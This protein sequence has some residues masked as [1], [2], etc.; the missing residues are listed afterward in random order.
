MMLYTLARRAEQRHLLAE[1][2]LTKRMQPSVEVWLVL[3]HARAFGA[4][5]VGGSATAIGVRVGVRVDGV[6][7]RGR[8]GVDGAVLVGDA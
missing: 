3:V 4:A 6:Q 7:M 5:G 1:T 2:V 8:G